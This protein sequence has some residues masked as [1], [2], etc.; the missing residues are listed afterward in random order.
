MRNLTEQRL[1]ISKEFKAA[2]FRTVYG[3]KPD[4][5]A[6]EL[7]PFA[8][9]YALYKP[10][11]DL[12][13]QR[14]AVGRLTIGEKAAVDGDGS[15]FDCRYEFG[16]NGSAIAG[17]LIHLDDRA[18]I[19]F[20]RPGSAQFAQLTIDQ[21]HPSTSRNEYRGLG[22]IWVSSMCKWQPSASPVYADRIER[23][24]F[25]FGTI[26][27]GALD[28]LPRGARER[29]RRGNIYSDDQ[30]FDLASSGTRPFPS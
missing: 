20:A 17:Q 3:L 19:V 26:P 24:D 12:P 11:D 2:V 21:F 9:S 28:A 6:E 13:N 16:A 7:V 30:L 10:S 23:E 25:A 22:G 8:G 1:L 5:N 14:I 29:L 15:P 27:D 18:L 4:F